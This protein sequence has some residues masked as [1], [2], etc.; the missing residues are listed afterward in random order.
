MAG[1]PRMLMRPECRR[2][3]RLLQTYLDDELHE[4]QVQVVGAHLERCDRC[5]LD[6][7]LIEAVR[8]AV[9]ELAVPTD[10]RAMLRLEGFLEQLVEERR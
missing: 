1:M 6:A 10:R 9:S 4:D 3:A 8:L 5:G 2:V 7:Q